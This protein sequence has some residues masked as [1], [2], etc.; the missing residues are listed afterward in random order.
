MTCA[1]V[2]GLKEP[3][4]CSQLYALDIVEHKGDDQG[5]S[6]TA[7]PQESMII[8]F[9]VNIS[10]CFPSAIMNFYHCWCGIWRQNV[11]DFLFVVIHNMT[12]LMSI[13]TFHFLDLCSEK[14]LKA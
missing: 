2:C 4:L 3:H 7:S 1:H 9:Q 8:L 13:T 5:L 12:A 10:S 11:T 6:G 14:L